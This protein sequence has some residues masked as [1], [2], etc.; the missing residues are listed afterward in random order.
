MSLTT[1]SQI[2][3][4]T[5]SFA[6]LFPLPLTPMEAFMV[7]DGR[8]GYAM[9]CDTELDFSG[10]IDRE[11]FETALAVA[12]A[13]NPLLRSLVVRDS[14]GALSWTLTDHMPHIDWAPWGTPVAGQFGQT[15]DLTREIGLRVWVRQGD[16]KSSVLCQFHHA[17]SDGVGFVAFCEDM[18]AA[19]SAALPGSVAVALRP[20]NPELL[21][22]RALL[23]IPLRNKLQKVAD[24]FLAIRESLRFLFQAPLALSAQ[25]DAKDATGHVVF[26]SYTFTDET[27]VNLRRLAGEAGATLNDLLLRDLMIALRRWQ[28]GNGR[29][30]RYRKLRILMPQNLRG[31]DD[32]AMPATIAMSFAFITRSASCCDDPD[33]LLRTI[34]A[35]TE[36]I[37]RHKLSLF[38]LGGIAS[39][40]GAGILDWLL[41]RRM[42]FATAVLTNLGNPTRR[43]VAR[44]P[45]SPEGLMAGNLALK[46]ITGVP[47]LRPLTRSVWGVFQTA[48]T[49]TISLKCDPQS[50]GPLDVERL[51]GEYVSQLRDSARSTAPNLPIAATG[52]APH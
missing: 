33:K 48:S 6:G 9:T 10:C 32:G 31:P 1:A 39:L 3:Y 22:R 4:D 40:Q 37:R 46:S 27:V 38:F 12:L 18:M 20:L 16:E 25:V 47:P 44:F 50:Y 35:E 26:S 36:A 2:D 28:S 49:L 7:A 17:C 51:L 19:Y 21:K 29:A 11:A 13:R 52:Q 42:C 34:S 14:A 43:F 41:R 23:S 30:P 5:P 8:E 15:V 24:V 45:R